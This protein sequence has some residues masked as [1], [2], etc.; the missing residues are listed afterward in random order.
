MVYRD[1]TFSLFISM[2][3]NRIIK[4]RRKP[5]QQPLDI[6][7]TVRVPCAWSRNQEKCDTIIYCPSTI[8]YVWS[9]NWKI[10]I[11]IKMVTFLSNQ[12]AF[13]LSSH[14]ISFHL[15]SDVEISLICLID[16]GA[17]CDRQ[18]ATSIP[19]LYCSSGYIYRVLLLWLKS[20][21]L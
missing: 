4:K 7:Q 11:Q 9:I 17:M 20:S 13:F 16:C 12:N 2:Y 14:F 8:L 1:D 18:F 5:K 15:I 3:I 6:T 10:F 19:T 21:E